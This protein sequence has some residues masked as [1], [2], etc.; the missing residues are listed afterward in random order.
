MLWMPGR[1]VNWVGKKVTVSVCVRLG[2]RE[3]VCQRLCFLFCFFYRNMI[4]FVAQI[5]KGL[6]VIL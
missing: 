4:P 2:R 6:N 5:I 1:F 3:H